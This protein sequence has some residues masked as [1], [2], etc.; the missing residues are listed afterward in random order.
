MGK[1]IIRLTESDLVKIVKRVR[2]LLSEG[3]SQT[4]DKNK[5][6]Q[7]IIT[8]GNKVKK[9]Y[10]IH[11]SKP[12]TISK[13]KK[14]SNVDLVKEFIPTIKYKLFSE[15]SAKN[16][17]VNRQN[18][19]TI[20][21]NLNNVIV[22]VGNDFSSKGTL[23]YDTILHEMAH[24]IDF[25]MRDLG[26]KTIAGS[27][28]YYDT[29]DGK[30]DYVD[31]DDETFA[32][33]QRLREVLELSPNADG[34]QIRNKIIKFINSK[35]L[36]FPGVKISSANEYNGLI[37]KP[38]QNSKGVLTELWKFYSPIKIDGT[39]VPDISALFGKFSLIK[40]DG[41]IFLNLDIIGKINFTTKKLPDQ[42]T[43]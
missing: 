29:T 25:K 15:K 1:K 22:K 31:S 9:Y 7:I 16:G 11:Y 24:L 2:P 12:E 32:R 41:S 39:S 36:L 40:K 28:G 27:E 42:P 4:D 8:E 20:N 37:F 38:T 5:I 35:R 23:L 14:R 21:L 3:G 17:F 19:N 26:E 34:N 33:V 13:F 18:P 43:P 10:Q 6:N 30:D